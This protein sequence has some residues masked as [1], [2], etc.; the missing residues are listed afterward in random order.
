MANDLL[1]QAIRTAGLDR[2]QIAD[3]V[4]V[5]PKTVER[6]IAGRLPHPR[7]RAALSRALGVGEE[8]I[9]PDAVSSAARERGPAAEI[10]GAWPRRDD[11]AAPD[12]RA[13]LRGAQTRVDLVGY[14]LLS[15][16]EAAG[17]LEAMVSKAREGVSI[18]VATV[19]PHAE[20]VLAADLAGR[21]TGRLIGRIKRA[22]E[23]L[24]ALSHEPG[25]ELRQHTV[26]T[27]HTVLRFDDQLLLTVH[28]HGT[29]GFQ[30]P[31]LHL[32]RQQDYGIFDQITGHLEAVWANAKPVAAVAE[33]E[34]ADAPVSTAQPSPA[35]A[36]LDRFDQVWRPG[37]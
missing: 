22:S 18:R 12:W 17:A 29:P 11:P 20:F 16:L 30:A 10:I 21:Q 3:L 28:L 5:D 33:S 25:I 35:D 2:D 32:R 23:V 34:P 4:Q 27:S 13:L 8:D 15:V 1:I 14:S 24:G 6:W 31:A 26:P 9:W 37:R 19:D 36:L 7:Y